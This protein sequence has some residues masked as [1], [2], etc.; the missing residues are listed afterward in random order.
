LHPTDGED[1]ECDS[2]YMN[3]IQ[4]AWKRHRKGHKQDEGG[5]FTLDVKNGFAVYEYK[6]RDPCIGLFC[7][8]M[9]K[10]VRMGLA[11]FVS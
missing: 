3:G 2:E 8:F 11:G 5:T 4:E 9:L 6:Y 7:I 10:C 1:G